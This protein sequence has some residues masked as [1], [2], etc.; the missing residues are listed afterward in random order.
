M[1]VTVTDGEGATGTG[2]TFSISGGAAAM[3]A[4]STASSVRPPLGSEPGW[5]RRWHALWARTHRLGRG[6]AVPALSAVDIAVWD[7]RARRAGCRCT[8][9]WAPTVTRFRPT[10]AWTAWPE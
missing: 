7:L 6:V 10:A 9:C 1:H 4:W 5:E 8:G 2:F 3:R